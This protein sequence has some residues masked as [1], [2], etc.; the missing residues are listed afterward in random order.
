V[1]DDKKPAE[2]DPPSIEETLKWEA[3]HRRRASAGSIAAGLA[4]IVGLVV[5]VAAESG[6]PKVTLLSAFQHA[7]SLERVDLRT[8]EFVYLSSHG[9]GLLIAY[10]LQGGAFLAA[11]LGIGYLYRATSARTS[12]LR[13]WALPVALIGLIMIAIYSGLL[14]AGLVAKTHAFAHSSNHSHDAANKVVVDNPLI[15]FASFMRFFGGLFLAFGISMISLNAM[16]CGLLTR[17]LGIL[18]IVGGV[19]YAF[20]LGTP[21]YP[22]P[23]VFYMIFLGVIIGGHWFSGVPPAWASGKAEPWPSSQE[24]RA[25]REAQR[26]EGGG[27][28]GG[29][30]GGAAGGG[31]GGLFGPRKTAP[32]EELSTA[33]SNGNGDAVAAGEAARAPH[34]S[35]K[36]RKRKRR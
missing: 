33:E 15:R 7:N 18:G 1:S 19:L 34:P 22:I 20:P 17:F 21:L 28:S 6:S 29:G 9:A 13:R 26:R 25:Q 36:K 10:L 16:R 14:G 23:F 5:Q 3:D 35:S 30:R 27:G 31:L 2:V 4:I 32:P 12:N 8:P 11:I 24:I